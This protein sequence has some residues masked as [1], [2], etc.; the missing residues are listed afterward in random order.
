MLFKGLNGKSYQ[1]DSKPLGSG[2]EGDIYAISGNASQVVKIYKK[3]STSQALE[4]KLKLMVQRPPSS[5]V[6]NQ[7]AWPLDVVYDSSGSFCGFV[8]PKL[9]ITHE[10]NEVY[11]YPPRTGITYKQKL[12][13]AQNICVVIHEVHKAGY[14]FGDF[15]PRN[16]GV[17]LNTGA[18]AFLDTDSYHIVIDKAS[19]RA[20]RCNVCAPG[21]AAPEL[22]KKCT[23][24]ISAHPEDK[25]QAYAKTPLD[26]FTKETDNF[27]LAIHMF[28]LLMNGFTPFNGIP[29][30]QSA[31]VGSPGQGDAAVRRDSYCFKKGNKP[32]AAAVPELDS[33]PK[34]IQ[35]YFTRAFIDGKK[36]PTRRPSALEWHKALESFERELVTCNVNPAHMYQKR[37]K[38]C[39]WCEA[40]SRY[41]AMMNP[42]PQPQPQLIQKAFTAPVVTAP[43][44][45]N[46]NSSGGVL[47][48][49][50][51]LSGTPSGIQ[52]GAPS[53]KQKVSSVSR[54]NRLNWI[55]AAGWITFFVSVIA[56]FMPLVQNG[57]I[58]LDETNIYQ[59]NVI[60]SSIIALIGVAA[61]CFAS[62]YSQ[63]PAAMLTIILS[64]IWGLVFS[65]T[66]ATVKYTQMGFSKVSADETWKIFGIFILLFAGAIAIP[67]KIASFLRTGRRT[68]QKVTRAQIRQRIKP[69]EAICIIVMAF[70]SIACIAL[71]WSLETYYH[72]VS[73]YN[74]IAIAIWVMPVIIF[75]IECYCLSGNSELTYTWFCAS[76]TS[77]F[78]C[79]VLWWGKVGGAGAIF[80]WLFLA[81]VA[82]LLLIFVGSEDI[83]GLLGGFMFFSF[84]VFFIV[85]AYADLEI[86]S[87]GPSAIGSFTHWL[88]VGPAIIITLISAYTTVKELFL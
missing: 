55:N 32:Q 62:H 78:T 77:F 5:S 8:M 53:W 25:K 73:N 36:D 35:D 74:L 2:G 30:T 84:F 34:T 16:I 11:V 20:Y 19:N 7:V 56:V 83:A 28:R 47:S 40:D 60:R 59:I 23:D 14:V 81:I 72:I 88:I 82:C 85:G 65:T 13:L 39:P 79:L 1:L 49:T 41:S 70:S 75:L 27:A 44:S 37:L 15:N 48:Q 86:M 57:S 46:I 63:S 87:K 76:M 24:H 54:G 9:D 52:A 68:R 69:F 3:S 71:M 67:S 17:N 33:L 80:G 29:E 66:A 4:E 58:H 10:L 43:T 38:S 64:G 42:Q 22:L 18:V 21:Y 31:S 26:T 12:I 51:T 45:S 6:L 50:N 61:L